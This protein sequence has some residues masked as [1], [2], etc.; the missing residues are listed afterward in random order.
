M[1]VISR[2]QIDQPFLAP[3]GEQIY[4]LI[5]DATDLG[6]ATKH[7]VAYAVVPSGK[8]SPRHY[9]KVSEETYYMLKGEAELIIDGRQ[10][11]LLPGQ[12]CLI[13]PGEVHQ[14]FNHASEDLEFLVVCAPPWTQN[15]SFE[16]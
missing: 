13:L 1:R 14:V 5:G 11:T 15:D 10:V 6:G 2:G 16:V 3:L 9:H 8:Q 7:S 12:A 4:E